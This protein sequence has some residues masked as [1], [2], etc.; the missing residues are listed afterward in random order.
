MANIYYAALV[1]L[2]VP[3]L[4]I[5]HLDAA[6][7]R[8]AAPDS[9]AGSA[10]GGST[11]IPLPVIFYQPE[12]GTGFGATAIYLF[13]LKGDTTR[14]ENHRLFQSSL[15][16]V[17]IYTT[18]KQVITSLNAELFPGGGRYRILTGLAYIRFPNLFWGIGNDTPSA[19]EEDYTPVLVAANGEIQKEFAPRWYAGGF[20]QIGIRELSTV[21]PEGLLDSGLVPG[22]EDGTVVTLGLLLTRDTRSSNTYPHWGSFHQLRASFSDGFFGSKY[23]FQT[24]TL[25][26]RTYLRMP[27]ASVLVLR[28][29]GVASGDIPP[30]DLLPQLG[31]ESLLRGYFAGRYRDRSLLAFQTEYR[32]PIWWRIGGTV[33]AAAGQVADDLGGVAFDRFHTSAGFGLRFQLD[34]QEELN[35]RMDFGWGF[36]I[37][38]SGFYLGFGEAF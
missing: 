16:A 13:T 7:A 1:L 9:A 21:E 27:S 31:G 28:G 15:S 19:V 6:Q 26:L 36:D 4:L 29:L 32:T 5:F 10:D 18:K 8:G 35:I 33:F 3:G 17:G 25:D 20:G 2:L 34:R 23:D 11:F 12:T 24:F 37:E 30:F 22:S 14:T 38:S